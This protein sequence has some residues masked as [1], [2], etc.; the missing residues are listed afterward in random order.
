MIIICSKC[1]TE[2]GSKEW[3]SGGD[4]AQDGTTQMYITC[5]ACQHK[6]FTHRENA[7]I[8]RARQALER[9]HVL[10]RRNPTDG[11]LKRV[12]TLK[13]KLGELF[14]RVNS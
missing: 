10:Y 4:V 7:A 6:Q 2:S 5:P 11:Q 9:A 12:E 1:K 8:V 3:R 13:S 14:D